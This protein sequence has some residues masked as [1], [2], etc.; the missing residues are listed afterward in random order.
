MRLAID[1]QC[2]QTDSRN[3]GVGRYAL[4]LTKAMLRVAG[5][6]EIVAVLN[7]RAPRDLVTIRDELSGL[8]A[9][10]NIRA[11]TGPEPGSS[12]APLE[13]AK[14]H[15][16]EL[17]R[18]YALANLGADAVHVSSL[19]EG[20]FLNDAITS[21]ALL[22][23]QPATGVVLYDLTPVFLQ[24]MYVPEGKVRDWYQGKL[25]HLRRARLLLAISEATRR[26]GIDV[27]A[28][29]PERIVNI[30]AG[31]DACF[32]AVQPDPEQ[33]ACF[34]RSRGLPEQ[35]ILYYGGFD[36]HKNVAGLIEA[37]G[38][39]PADMRRA[40]PLVFV[41]SMP[42][43]L[44]PPLDAV[45]AR[46]G[47]SEAE[48]RFLG[49]VGDADL[50]NLLQACE[51]AVYPSL[52]EG[53]GLP[54]L[55]AMAAGAAVICSDSSSLPEVI[56]RADAMFDP[57]KPASIAERLKA[58]VDDPGF[59]AELRAYGRERAKQFS[60]E[61]SA[62]KTLDAYEAVHAEEARA[63]KA[64]ARVNDLTL[65]QR[66]TL[67]WLADWPIS[68]ARQAA[69]RTLA[70][71][72]EIDLF[73]DAPA[74]SAIVVAGAVTFDIALH[75]D[76]LTRYDRTIIDRADAAAWLRRGPGVVLAAPYDNAASELASLPS[77]LGLLRSPPE[78]DAV[79]GWSEDAVCLIES[80]HLSA[81][82]PAAL[83]RSLARVVPESV[84]AGFDRALAAA[85]VANRPQSGKPRLL[86]DVTGTSQAAPKGGIPRVVNRL[87]GALLAD[88]PRGIDIALVR[89]EAGGAV[90][91]A[92]DYVSRLL[93]GDSMA[94]IVEEVVEPRV[95]DGFLAL[96]LNWAVGDF[97]PL[98]ARIRELGGQAFAVV[99][100]LLPL[101]RPEW[102]PHGT[103]EMHARWFAAIAEF[104]GLACISQAVANDVKGELHRIGKVGARPRLGWFHLGADF[105][106]GGPAAPPPELGA[107]R[108]VLHVAQ[109]WARKGH[110]Q[111]LAAF[112]ALWAEGVD[113]N[114]VMVGPAGFGVDALINRVRRHREYGRR[115]HWFVDA[116]DPVLTSLYRTVDGV[117]VPS[118]GEGFGLP[119]IEAI[120]FGRPVL[121]RDLPVFREII[122]D[123]ARYFE[124]LNASALA[125]ALRGWLAEID[126]GAAPR[127]DPARLLS[128]AESARELTKVLTEKLMDPP[129]WS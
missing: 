125:G 35:F 27:L 84:D 44:R 90:V 11:W 52:R 13:A 49:R 124:G 15:C 109:V 117:L 38:S 50:L 128:W 81:S 41:G 76:R 122:G 10:R 123:G 114:Y 92:R 93:G 82:S 62:R 75:L 77:C 30:S 25:R 86:V 112:E 67:A 97:A 42:D 98:L 21:V 26:E 7:G 12:H 118:E 55:E 40:H 110:V 66:P 46:A 127:G 57:T 56:G 22:G 103:D 96:D 24:S 102:F 129:I 63:R 53:F 113:V 87:V 39:L 20:M 45:I 94:E 80:G 91:F 100:D 29:P 108:T 120:H 116:P 32:M 72:Y 23:A 89:F 9:P 70:K 126:A 115:L 79:D 99:Y 74:T 121:C 18:E 95:G 4:N 17:M 51:L 88:P 36:P 119:L 19:F 64:G 105:P 59:R 68:P 61:A 54:V 65:S 31:V 2:W 34:K 3:R 43:F 83:A 73:V 16:V 111:A 48:F 104:D 85:I 69:I 107:R 71:T 8:I 37:F 28:L 5:R 14:T 1:L 78:G 6:H 101:Q 60:W 106:D 47:L 58:V 33:I